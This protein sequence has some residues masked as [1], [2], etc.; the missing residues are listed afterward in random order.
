MLRSPLFHF[1]VLGGALFLIDSAWSRVPETSVVRVSRGEIESRVLAYQ[2]QMGRAPT[3]EEVLAFENQVIGEAIWL[4]EAFALGL[5]RFDPV[6][7]QR[8]LLNMRFLE[9]ANEDEGRD[10]GALLERAFELG[11]ERSDTVVQRR[12]VDRMQA[13]VRARVRQK[14]TSPEVLAAYFRDNAERWREPSLLDFSHVY[15]S[16][17]KHGEQ[18]ANRAEALLPELQS[19]SIDPEEA[20]RLGDPFLSGHR[21]RGAS[22][23]RIATRF[24][25]AFVDGETAA[26]VAGEPDGPGARLGGIRDAPVEQWIGPV[27]SAFGSHLVWIHERKPSRVPEL[28]EI[29]NRVREDYFEHESR[30]AIA[31]HLDRRRAEVEILIVEKEG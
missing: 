9:G 14:G 27:D 4:E 22:P 18:T 24:G 17:D 29:E 10:D 2:E 5:E 31:A 7:Q 26:G 21:L 28:R 8:L 16:R 3:P 15:F 23:R 19:K 1:L 30:K 6:V 12:L 25:P 13:L 11:M 20:I